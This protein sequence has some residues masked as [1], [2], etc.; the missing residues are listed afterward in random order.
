MR[1]A[2]PG[3]RLFARRDPVVARVAAWADEDP[4]A[5]RRLLVDEELRAQLLAALEDLVVETRERRSAEAAG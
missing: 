2:S 3:A 5:M 4:G 1:G